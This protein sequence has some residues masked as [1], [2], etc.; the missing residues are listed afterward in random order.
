MSKSKIICFGEVLWD[1]LPEELGGRI[2][3]GAPMNVA[4]HLNAL[5]IDAHI[6]S[7]VG[8]DDLGTEL[9]E[10]LS[11]KAIST[12]F[13][14]M[15]NVLMTGV[16]DVTLDEKGSPSYK[17]IEPVAWDNIMLTDDIK[18]KV[19]AT[20]ALVFGSLICRN[21]ASKQTLFELLDLSKCPVFDVNLREP[22]YSQALIE[23]L[24]HKAKI[25]K[26]NEHEL[27]IISQWH[28]RETDFTEQ[29][30]K[31][32]ERYDI[33]SLIVSHGSKGAYCFEN[34]ILYFQ[35]AFEITVKDTIGSGDAFLAGFL[36]EKMKGKDAHTCL[37][38][39]CAM[40][41]YVA[42]QAGATP[43]VNI[44]LV[45]SNVGFSDGVTPSHPVT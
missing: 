40:G 30:R 1:L 29:I 19:E 6:I 43:S 44:G 4:Y 32:Q 26:T 45:M 31:V 28:S 21:E 7:R 16:V 2:A 35:K 37:K 18:E 38:T 33:E 34:G 23:P 17:I 8:N 25:V 39:A 36:S 41:A 27:H 15:D 3:G 14:Q 10:F 11:Q 9:K 13:V 22:F 12:D 24:L 42:T 20:D 5:G